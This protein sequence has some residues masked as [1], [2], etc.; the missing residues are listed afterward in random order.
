VDAGRLDDRWRRFMR[1]QIERNRR[2]YDEA[3][4]GIALLHPDGR[5][6]IT[7]AADLYRAILAD[8]EANDYDVFRR[9][10]HVSKTGKLT[11]LPRIWWRSRTVSE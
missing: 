6:A 4:P 8:I 2:L 10:A 1:F 11:R 7:A 5:L 3:L 9:R